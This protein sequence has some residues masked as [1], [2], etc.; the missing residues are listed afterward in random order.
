[1]RSRTTGRFRRAFAL[2]PKDI[3]AQARRAYKRFKKDPKHPSLQ[4]KRIHPTKPVYS[5]RI[6][7]GYRAVGARDGDQ[8]A[9]YWIGSHADYD[10]LGR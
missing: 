10:K 1:L 3:K 2:L 4:F 9:W 8:I 6:G 7:L 5:V